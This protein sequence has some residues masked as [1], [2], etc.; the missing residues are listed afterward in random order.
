MNH[1]SDPAW[2]ELLPTTLT[3]QLAAEEGGGGG[4]GGQKGPTRGEKAFILTHKRHT[5]LLL[6]ST[7]IAG[8]L[9]IA[10]IS[11]E[12]EENKATWDPS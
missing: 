7:A 1:T 5:Y 12:R 4:G 11:R 2:N 6:C 8:R 3:L 9:F 10:Q